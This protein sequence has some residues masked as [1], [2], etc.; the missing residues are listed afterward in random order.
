MA[1]SVLFVRFY[2]CHNAAG[3]GRA[4][5]LMLNSGLTAAVFNRAA[6]NISADAR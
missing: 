4:D 1:A 6:A 3:I 2:K 5:R